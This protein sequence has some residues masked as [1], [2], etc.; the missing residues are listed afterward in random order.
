MVEKPSLSW[1]FKALCKMPLAYCAVQFLMFRDPTAASS[2]TLTQNTTFWFK[3]SEQATRLSCEY[4]W[5]D[6]DKKHFLFATAIWSFQPLSLFTTSFFFVRFMHKWIHIYLWIL[7][8]REFGNELDLFRCIFWKFYHKFTLWLRT[9][10]RFELDT[11]CFW[12]DMNKKY[13]WALPIFCSF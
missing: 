13:G 8:Y 1:T 7:W 6:N 4:E 10:S 3:K 5:T 12:C 11:N 9:E 2:H